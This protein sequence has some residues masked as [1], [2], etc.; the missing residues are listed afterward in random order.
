[1]SSVIQREAEPDLQNITTDLAMNRNSDEMWEAVLARDFRYYSSFVYAVKSSKIFCRPTCPS[2]K[3]MRDRVEFYSTSGLAQSAGYRPCLRCKPETGEEVPAN[4]LS[5]QKVCTF[6]EDNYA[7]K[8]SLKR[9]AEVAG[10]SPFHFHRNFRKVIG[11]TPRQYL[12]EIRLKRAKLALKM[13]ES[14]RNSTYRAGHNSASWL[15][16]DGSTAKFGMSPAAYKSGGEG[17]SIHYTISKCSLGKVL[18]ASTATGICF[19]CLGD[20]ND[21]LLVH[22]QNEYPNA[23][24]SPDNGRSGMEEWVSTILEYLEGR[25]RLEQVGGLP[26]DVGATAFQLRVWRELQKIPYGTTLSYNEVAERIGNPRA[27]RAVANACASN[28]VPLVIPCHRVVR[29][30][31]DLGG[32]RWGVD[33]KK[34]LLAMEAETASVKS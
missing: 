32:Y 13:G 25:T 16:S 24:I 14:T 33:R 17:L 31:G 22:L 4:V 7:S 30:N 18:V 29:K 28:R 19:L 9:L 11:V 6:L 1:M 27:Y 23:N 3:P 12:E 34:K 2:R 15:Y 5:V 21:R 10:Q 8:I 20:S 26:V